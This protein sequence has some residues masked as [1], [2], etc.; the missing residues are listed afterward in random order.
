MVAYTWTGI[1]RTLDDP[2]LAFWELVWLYQT[3]VRDSGRRVMERDWDN[4]IIL[5]ACRYDL[6]A[7]NNTIPGELGKMV[8]RGSHTADFLNRNFGSETFPDTI[9]VSATPQFLNHGMHTRFYESVH[10]WESAWDSELRT[11]PPEKV[12]EA[13]IDIANEHPDKR[14][15]SHF[16]QPHYP[17]IGETG[18]RIEHGTLTGGGVMAEERDH[19][20]VWE[21]LETG[22]V[23]REMVEDAYRENLELVLPHVEELLSELS[24]KS[25]VTA[26]HGNSFGKFGVYG[27]PRKRFLSD[28][29]DVPWLVVD[30]G[31]RRDITEGGVN[32]DDDTARDVGEHLRALGYR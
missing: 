4:L 9:Y 29:V 31:E 28:L 26:D 6:F 23:S 12:V 5:D 7:E 17:F 20:S 10:L 3:R 16:L 25:V 8:S 30:D 32:D 24:G 15:I 1:K 13:T 18:K 14:I 2:R 11:V 27:H 22:D 19:E 21:L